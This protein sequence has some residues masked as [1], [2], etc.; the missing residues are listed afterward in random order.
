MNVKG[1]VKKKNCFDLN[2]KID[3]FLL[4]CLRLTRN[5]LKFPSPNSQTYTRDFED[6][7]INVKMT[8]NET[9]V[10]SR[11]GFDFTGGKCEN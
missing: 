8:R 2:N 3:L 7:P 11:C 5:I 9:F 10:V 6:F 1:K 4:V